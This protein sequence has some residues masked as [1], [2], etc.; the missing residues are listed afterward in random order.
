MVQYPEG[1]VAYM[2]ANKVQG[3]IFHDYVWGGYLI[4]KIPELKVFID[5]R[6][7][8]YAPNG[9]FK[10]YLAAEGGQNPQAVLDKYQVGYVLVSADSLLAQMLKN[11]SRW[12]VRYSDPTSVLLQRSST[13]MR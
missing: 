5:G 11:S 3:R 9:V 7:Y 8:Q 12:T 2:K 13:A 4:W 6:Q 1:A 10:D